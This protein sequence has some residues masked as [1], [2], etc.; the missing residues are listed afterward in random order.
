V[1]AGRS[2][3]FHQCPDAHTRVHLKALL[4]VSAPPHSL[5]LFGFGGQQS[6]NSKLPTPL[7]FRKHFFLAMSALCLA[8]DIAKLKHGFILVK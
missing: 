8:A 6:A 4:S 7:I 2:L 5:T 3:S 1:R